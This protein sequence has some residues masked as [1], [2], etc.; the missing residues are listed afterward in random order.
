[1]PP[2]L[3]TKSIWKERFEEI[4][5]YERDLTRNDVVIRKFFLH[6]SKKEQKRRFLERIDDAD[7]NWKFS[8]AGARERD[9]WN[10]SMDAYEDMIVHTATPHAPWFVVP[11]D[12]K[13]LTRLAVAA[14]AIDA[15]SERGLRFPKLDAAKRR[16]LQQVKQVLAP[17]GKR[18]KQK[19]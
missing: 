2:S 1:M 6:V 12:N 13:W 5:A 10:E 4:D 18:P 3:V 8:M 17:N 19:S 15:L 14:A 16:E 9:H 11:A 7:K